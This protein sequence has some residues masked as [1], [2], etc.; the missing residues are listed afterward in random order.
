MAAILSLLARLSGKTNDN[1][2]FDTSKIS[3]ANGCTPMS[4]GIFLQCSRVYVF[5]SGSEGGSLHRKIPVKVLPNSEK[6]RKIHLPMNNFH[7][8]FLAHVFEIITE[9][10]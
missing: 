3:V 8:V 2:L 9:I 4:V 10:L 6:S 7:T 1:T 5:Y